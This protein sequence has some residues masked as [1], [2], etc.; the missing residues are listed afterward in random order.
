M[1]YDYTEGDYVYV[2]EWIQ[3]QRLRKRPW[4]DILLGLQASPDLLGSFFDNQK[5]ME[6]WPDDITKD[7]FQEIVLEQK[8]IEEMQDSGF[9]A[10][11]PDQTNDLNPSTRVD[12][13]WQC[14]KETLH[15]NHFNPT[16]ISH[17]ENQTARILS[18]LSNDTTGLGR[19]D[20][21]KGLVI[22]NVQSGK[23]ANMEALMSM[24][25]DYGWNFYIILSG[26]IENL[27][28]QTQQRFKDDLFRHQGGINWAE[29]DRPELGRSTSL[30]MLYLNRSNNLRYFTVCLK[31][32]TRLNRLIKWLHSDINQ[33]KNLRILVIDDECDQAGVNT[34]NIDEDEK[35]RIYSCIT[36]LVN[37]KDEKGKDLPVKYGAMNYVGYSATPY[38]N[39]LNDGKCE[40]LYPK[41]FIS[42]L[43]VSK[44]Y[45]GPQ[46]IFGNSDLGY[47]GLSIINKVSPEDVDGIVDLH[48]NTDDGLPDSLK[49]SVSWFLCCTACQ[50]YKKSLKPVSMLIHTSQKTDHHSRIAKGVQ[51]W[52]KTNSVNNIL[53]SCKQEWDKQTNLFDYKKL[54]EQYPDFMD[55]EGVMKDYPAF[56]DIKPYL[57]EILSVN[58]NKYTYIELGDDSRKEFNKGIHICV[59]NCK[60]NVPKNKE[61]DGTHYHLR[62]AYPQKS[63]NV[64]FAS[65]FIVIGGATLSRGLT[66]E[67]LVCSYFLRSVNYADTLM[68][69]GRWFGYRRGYE[70]LPRLWLTDNAVKQFS[71][72]STM[73]YELRENIREMEESK[74]TPYQY[75]VKVLRPDQRVIKIVSKKKMQSVRIRKDFSGTYKQTYKFDNNEESMISN[76]DALKKF[77][78]CLGSPNNEGKN[79]YSRN[80]QVWR[81]VDVNSVLG[82]LESYKFSS[83]LPECLNVVNWLGSDKVK[84]VLKKWN[85]VLAGNV[86]A[87]ETLGVFEYNGY[88]INK[89]NRSRFSEFVEEDNAIINIGTLRNPFDLLADIDLIKN[90]EFEFILNSAEVGRIKQIRR[91]SVEKETPQLLI[92]VISSKSKAERGKEK[93][94]D[95]NVNQD[96]VGL[97]INIPEQSK[98]TDDEEDKDYYVIDF[99]RFD[100]NDSVDINE[101][102]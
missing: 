16:A 2:W 61:D 7:I 39:I 58:N 75:K 101:E 20:V 48:N 85:I 91:Q 52:L 19:E 60:N 50:R 63:D 70:L 100:I 93:R 26:T 33:M 1:N 40:S 57:I 80:A 81:D 84:D 92:Y 31:N 23:T 66:L 65:A 96:L 86:N 6:L 44:E 89:V 51:N 82:F 46:Q 32:S 79:K 74:K 77:L 62:L 56:E 47:S 24:T 37:Q 97:S 98:S 88:S 13:A 68:Q 43:S 59:D 3:K 28:N 83:A 78:D 12:S 21:V 25:A 45:F 4:N 99:D 54:K 102:V 5:K 73:D 55:D 30:Q 64:N 9:I 41:N 36:N 49:Q 69:M 72:L 42:T 35:T 17:I 34:A 15:D 11:D 18:H 22:G 67:G 10:S 27:R 94:T 95:L 76:L 29:I 71:Y 87:S 8:R 53:I 14:F 38:A 90:P